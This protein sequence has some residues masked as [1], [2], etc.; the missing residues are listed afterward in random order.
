VSYQAPLFFR[1]LQYTAH[2]PLSHAHSLTHSLTPTGNSCASSRSSIDRTRSSRTISRRSS[3]TAP[4]SRSS[5]VC[6][7]PTEPRPSSQKEVVPPSFR[8]MQS[9]RP[10]SKNRPQDLR[11]QRCRSEAT[12]QGMFPRRWE[13]RR[14]TIWLTLCN[15]WASGSRLVL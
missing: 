7:E 2:S 15:R 9:D 12:S 6:S 14:R 13:R 5:Q 8:H 1:K 11:H 10:I 4:L 3:L